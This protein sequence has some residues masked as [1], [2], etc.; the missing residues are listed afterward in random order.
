MSSVELLK[1][2]TGKFGVVYV[3]I[4]FCYINMRV[5]LYTI[6][7]CSSKERFHGNLLEF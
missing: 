1:Q 3:G 7:V 4:Y 6:W 5:E 2:G